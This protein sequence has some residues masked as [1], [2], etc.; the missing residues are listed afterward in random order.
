MIGH[1]VPW[2]MKVDDVGEISTT[3][4]DGMITPTLIGAVPSTNTPLTITFVRFPAAATVTDTTI[5]PA[6][7]TYTER[8]QCTL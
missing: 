5:A 1:F 3:C 6:T 2:V 7:M 8:T 4:P